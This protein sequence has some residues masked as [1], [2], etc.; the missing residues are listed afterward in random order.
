VLWQR[1]AAGFTAGQQRELAQ[2]VIGQLGIGQ[3]KPARLNPQIEREGWRL[4]GSLERLDAGQKAK[5]GDELLQRIR[6]E[7]RNAAR[8][9]TLGRLGARAPLYG[10]LNTVVPPIVA[11]RWMEAADGAEGHRSGRRGRHRPDRRGNRRSRARRPAEVR[12]RAVTRLEE[13]GIP[14]EALA[15]LRTVVRPDRAAATRAF[16]E[17]LPQGL[18]IS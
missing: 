10:P 3:K 6:R 5:L 17:S 18:R 16:G 2:R 9:W 11:E 15:P 4:L 14:P 13:A 8:L 1:V 12:Q 7:P